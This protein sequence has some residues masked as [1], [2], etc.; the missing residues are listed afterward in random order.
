MTLFSKSCVCGTVVVTAMTAP[1][2]ADTKLAV[3]SIGGDAVLRYSI[4]ADA[5]YKPF[6]HMVG[7]GVTGSPGLD[8]TAG[9]RAYGGD[10]LFVCSFNTD[11]I[12]VYNKFTGEYL[13]AFAATSDLDGP[14]D[15]AVKDGVAYV[16]SRWNNRIL[17]YDADSG[18]YLGQFVQSGVG[19][20]NNPQGVEIGPDGILY[21]ASQ[22]SNSVKKYSLQTQAFLG[23]LP[24]PPAGV[25]L[26]EPVGLAFDTDGKLYVSGAGSDNVLRYSPT[27]DFETVVVATGTNSID[28]RLM[29]FG[30]DGMLYIASS[31]NSAVYRYE[32]DADALLLVTVV[33][34]GSGGLVNAWGLEFLPDQ[35]SADLNA[36]GEVSGADLGMLLSS[37]GLC[38]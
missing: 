11:R 16:T 30:P 19:G 15:I 21:V 20:L 14:A 18:I 31:G 6:D 5:A 25:S 34:P 13:S 9:I 8:A 4:V 32:P 17:R 38:P 1:C 27:G 26:V 29:R 33:S 28:P 2:A 7:I 10:K 23:T 37:W 36:D 35:C 3:S 12:F 22:L 24:N